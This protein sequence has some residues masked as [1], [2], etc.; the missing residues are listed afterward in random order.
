MMSMFHLATYN[1]SEKKFIIVAGHDDIND[2][3]KDYGE[4]VLTRGA[5]RVK[6]LEELNVVIDID[7]KVVS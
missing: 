5:K 2:A 3:V 1:E 7:V 4:E 6:L